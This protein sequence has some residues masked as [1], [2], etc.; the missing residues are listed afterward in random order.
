[1]HVGIAAI[2]GLRLGRAYPFAAPQRVWFVLIKKTCICVKDELIRLDWLLIASRS[3][4]SDL[5]VREWLAASQQVK[6]PVVR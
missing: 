2:K 5:A 6:C 3:I 1:M 4:N